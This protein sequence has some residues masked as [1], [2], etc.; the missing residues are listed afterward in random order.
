LGIIAE[1]DYG[2]LKSKHAKELKKRIERLETIQTDL[3]DAFNMFDTERDGHVQRKHVSTVIMSAGLVPTQK[4]LRLSLESCPPGPVSKAKV[5]AI[6]KKLAMDTVSK[7]D[8]VEAFVE[9]FDKERNGYV[10]TREIMEAAKNLEQTDFT[11]GDL[12]QLLDYCGVKD[13]RGASASNE[14]VGKESSLD[15]SAVLQIL[16]DR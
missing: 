7:E 8:M 6:A 16:W 11:E 14:L 9:V 15:A 10:D 4:S 12:Q 2:E 1:K 5:F 13:A 3:N